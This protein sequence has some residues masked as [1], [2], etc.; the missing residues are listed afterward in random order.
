VLW[1]IYILRLRTFNPIP[2]EQLPFISVLV[3]ARNE[4]TKIKSCLNSILCQNYPRYEVI[5]LDD[6]STDGTGNT[7]REI[8][9]DNQKLKVLQGSE[10]PEGWIGKQYACFQLSKEAKGDWLLFTDADTIHR[11]NAL[12]SA[13]T[14]ALN[15]KADL[16]SLIPYQIMKTFSEKL[17]IPIFHFTTLTFLPFYFLE[18]SY[19]P[20]F[21][22][23]IGQFMLF[24][25]KAFEKI[26]GYESIKNDM[27]D[28]VW[29]ARKIKEY[30]LRLI[31]ADGKNILNCRMY[32]SFRD[33]WEGFSKN[34]YSGL[35]YNIFLAFIII[36][37]YL[38]L[39]IFPFIFLICTVVLKEFYEINMVLICSQVVLN[40]LMRFSLNFKFRLNII[41]DLL[42]PVGILMIVLIAFNSVRIAV[43]GQGPVWKGR[44]YSFKN[45]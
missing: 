30:K 42:H 8:K 31:V 39:F 45:K 5:V 40:Y 41:S 12:R 11:E 29:I 16:L 4:E 21:T 19:N 18:N 14:I 1:N 44:T 13:V 3:P 36:L 24:K 17:I 26:G 43:F 22:I 2:D 38:I 35:G 37:L 6:N 20:K 28:D 33:I 7:I 34:I 27:V 25:R 9:T 10:I 15:R 23:G 32:E